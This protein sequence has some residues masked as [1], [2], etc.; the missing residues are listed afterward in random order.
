M[1]ARLRERRRLL[2]AAVLIGLL[3]RLLSMALTY[4]S[5]PSLGQS[6]PVIA[7]RI[8]SEASSGL[9][10][11]LGPEVQTVLARSIGLT[12]LVVALAVMLALLESWRGEKVRGRALSFIALA[13]LHPAALIAGATGSAASFVS[14]GVLLAV[15]A[16]KA[17]RDGRLD[18]RVAIALLVADA[19]LLMPPVDGLLIVGLMAAVI[20]LQPQERYEYRGPVAIRW[21]LLLGI[22]YVFRGPILDTSRRVLRPIAALIP[23]LAF[24]LSASLTSWGAVARGLFGLADVTLRMAAP[25]VLAA[26]AVAAFTLAVALAGREAG[27]A[28]LRTYRE[29]GEGPS[30]TALRRS[31]WTFFGL[32]LLASAP[33]AIL[34]APMLNAGDVQP[35]PDA[36]TTAAAPWLAALGLAGLVLVALRSGAAAAAWHVVRERLRSVDS[37]DL[38]VVVGAAYLGLVRTPSGGAGWAWVGGVATIV[39]VSGVLARRISSRAEAIFLRLASLF[40]GFQTALS[41]W[42]PVSPTAQLAWNTVQLDKAVPIIPTEPTLAATVVAAA[43]L[44]MTA[45]LVFVVFVDTAETDVLAPGSVAAGPADLRER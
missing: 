30:R 27:S 44:A 34:M 33:Q 7:H 41:L 3:L 19:L 32:L 45:V 9:A 6:S 24:Q 38:A 10:T 22:A 36:L 4:R 26:P 42:L 21:A 2:L 25:W 31:G 12:I 5:A 40:M 16:L 14:L 13:V 1:I 17:H 28:A 37:L 35:R 8:V 39:L 29:L 43:A 23:Q 18:R 20:L 15:L 11:A